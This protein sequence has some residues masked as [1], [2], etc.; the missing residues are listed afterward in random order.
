MPGPGNRVPDIFGWHGDR[1][2]PR[3][4]CGGLQRRRLRGY[5]GIRL[6]SRRDPGADR[7]GSRPNPAAIRGQLHHRRAR[8]FRRGQGDHAPASECRDYRAGGGRHPLLGRSSAVRGG[9][10]P[11]WCSD[12]HPGRFARRGESGGAQGV[13]LGTRF[14]AS[15][16]F[17][18]H[19][20][21]K[22]R[23]VEGT[24]SDTVL[25]ELYDVWWPNAP[26]RTLRNK[27]LAEWEAA[28]RPP[29][30]HRPGEGTSIGRRRIGSGD[31]VDWPRYA[32]GVAPPDFDGDIEY[33]PL[34]AGESCS[35]VNDIKPAGDIVRDLA[36][37][38]DAILATAAGMPET[39][40]RPS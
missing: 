14:V 22:Q 36:R 30:G 13:S 33:A 12:H 29:S 10:T 34:W 37:D 1:S 2:G 38:A 5:R 15:D 27:T 25:N 19:P 20:A 4:R 11:T 18:A 28:G 16:E 3:S 6:S 31:I 21:Y 17:S 39:E 35:V 26:H 23:I 8:F 32:I 24:A 9:S 7:P 40:S